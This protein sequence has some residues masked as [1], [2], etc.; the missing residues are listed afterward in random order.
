[1]SEMNRGKARWLLLGLV[2]AAI[3]LTH[4]AGSG[5]V[6]Y[7]QDSAASPSA[8]ASPVTPPGMAPNIDHPHPGFLWVKGH[9]LDMPYRE[10]A[11]LIQ[12][13]LWGQ[14]VTVND[15]PC[16]AK[17]EEALKIDR[18]EPD[19]EA[20]PAINASRPEDLSPPQTPPQRAPADQPTQ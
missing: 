1:M 17:L 2:W 9:P 3:S 5:T 19:I 10:C 13:T 14:Q 20:E 11:E 12:R 8:Q 6:A 15:A 16:K 7:A 18:T 4:F